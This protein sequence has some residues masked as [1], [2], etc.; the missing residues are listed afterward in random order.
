MR[1]VIYRGSH[2]LAQHPACV[3]T[4]NFENNNTLSS[5]KLKRLEYHGMLERRTGFHEKSRLAWNQF[6]RS[7]VLGKLGS[8]ALI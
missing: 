4:A 6:V 1:V 8:D 2:F 7:G 3:P 5:A